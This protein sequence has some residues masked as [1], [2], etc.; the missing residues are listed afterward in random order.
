MRFEDKRRKEYFDLR[1][2][3]SRASSVSIETVL[4]AGRLVNRDLI[5]CRGKIFMSSGQCPKR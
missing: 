3:N 5:L 1:R 2:M 4:R